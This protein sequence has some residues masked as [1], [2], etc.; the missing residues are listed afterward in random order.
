MQNKNTKTPRKT[1]KRV[2]LDS[3]LKNLI[4]QQFSNPRQWRQKLMWSFSNV[5]NNTTRNSM[6]HCTI[7]SIE[8]VSNLKD[9]IG[10]VYQVLIKPYLT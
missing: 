7:G 9:C 3:I 4:T 2:K 5:N 8:R 6:N 10:C 1:K